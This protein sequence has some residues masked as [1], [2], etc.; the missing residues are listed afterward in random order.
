MLLPSEQHHGSGVR[1]P[2]PS[3][4]TAASGLTS[5]THQTLSQRPGPG[6]SDIS[7]SLERQRVHTSTYP[8]RGWLQPG[9]CTRAHRTRTPYLPGSA[10][11]MSA[12]PAPMRASA[13]SAERCAS[14]DGAP[15]NLVTTPHGTQGRAR[16]SGAQPGQWIH[17]C[18]LTSSRTTP[19]PRA[20]VLT[21]RTRVYVSPSSGRTSVAEA[22]PRT[23]VLVLASA[24]NG[25][26]LV[27]ARCVACSRVPFYT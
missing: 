6:F 3:E 20:A 27:Q 26:G 8:E 21:S 13:G 24:T 4:S 14:R 12:L 22:G 2:A 18:R 19:P 10:S 11:L 15:L 1:A 9:G 17:P 23:T 5:S 25:H 7:G 16:D